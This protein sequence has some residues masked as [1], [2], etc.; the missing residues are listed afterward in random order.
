MQDDDLLSPSLA[1]TTLVP[2]YSV[3]ALIAAAFFGGGLA[4]TMVAMINAS[5]LKRLAKDM[6]WLLLAAALSIGAVI[7]A[8]TASEGPE[9]PRIPSEARIY[10]RA[11]GFGL[12][13]AF[14]LLHRQVY[15][16][17]N[18]SGRPPPSPYVTVAVAVV[19]SFGINLL[20]GT[21]VAINGELA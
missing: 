21:L 9:S 15:R 20:V 13:G 16:T 2:I 14:F 18:L 12:C 11:I 10:I 19:A 8:I 1:E 3:G 7:W 5:R 6:I 17:M 4:V